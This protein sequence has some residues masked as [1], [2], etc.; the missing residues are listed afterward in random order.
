M[1]GRKIFAA[2]ISPFQLLRHR[3]RLLVVVDDNSYPANIFEGRRH[4]AIDLLPAICQPAKPR[5]ERER[6]IGRVRLIGIGG[7]GDRRQLAARY[8]GAHGRLA[9]I[10]R[11]L[12]GALSAGTPLIS[13][14]FAM[15]ISGS[16]RR[17][18]T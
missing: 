8:E 1:I 4:G 11:R 7:D 10:V 16:S 13:S 5:R 18:S 3:R 2:A 14:S 6:L 15:T 12:R 17:C 9:L